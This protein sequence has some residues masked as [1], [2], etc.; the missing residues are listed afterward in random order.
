MIAE[1]FKQCSLNLQ[2]VIQAT[3]LKKKKK[4]TFAK[5]N[6]Y[7][8]VSKP[9]TDG[10]N[11]LLYRSEAN[12]KCY[13]CAFNRFTIQ[14]HSLCRKSID[15]TI[16]ISFYG[17]TN[18][19]PPKLIGRYDST[20]KN[21]I[22]SKNETF[23]LQERNSTKSAGQFKFTEIELVQIPTFADYLRSGI[24]IKPIVAIDFSSLNQKPNDWGSLHLLSKNPKGMNQYQKC[25][26]SVGKVMT[27]YVKDN[28]FSIFWYG[29]KYDD[30]DTCV[31]PLTNDIKNTEVNG[32][33]GMLDAYLKTIQKV[34]L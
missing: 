22:N 33:Q 8:N 5:N 11:I 1:Q 6:P 32:V 4:K 14:I 29:A 20:I 30:Q 24:Q 10:H 19:K 13:S 15:E 26:S 28:K 31:F 17:F 18:K 3:Q 9:S 27:K 16:T 21:F 23:E 2:G 7:F 25:I 12:Y 34:K